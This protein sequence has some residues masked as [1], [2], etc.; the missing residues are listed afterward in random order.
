MEEDIEEIDA[1][2]LC[3]RDNTERILH[4]NDRGNQNFAP[5]GRGSFDRG[6]QNGSQDGRQ[7][8]ENNPKNIG[9]GLYNQGQNRTFHSQ[10]QDGAKPAKWDATFQAYDTDSKSLLEALKKLAAYTT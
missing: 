3:P 10:Y 8:F 2:E 6:D 7:N 1:M 4:G 5:I 9:R